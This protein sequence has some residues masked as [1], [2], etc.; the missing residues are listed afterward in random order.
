MGHWLL[1]QIQAIQTRKKSV[2]FVKWNKTLPSWRALGQCWAP[3]LARDTFALPRDYTCL[4]TFS[5]IEKRLSWN[6]SII[7]DSNQ[8]AWCMI[9]IAKPLHLC[10]APVHMFFISA[11]SRLGGSV[12]SFPV[13]GLGSSLNKK[14]KTKQ[15][16]TTKPWNWKIKISIYWQL[17][18]PDLFASSLFL[19]SRKLQ[20]TLREALVQLVIFNHLLN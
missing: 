15:Q 12:D 16:K 19:H 4:W 14:A 7:L 2:R 13:L 5:H 17:N 9:A 1:S 10:T 3:E 20:E 6:V 18:S 8:S 11:V